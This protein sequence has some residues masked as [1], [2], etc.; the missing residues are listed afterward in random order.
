MELIWSRRPSYDLA[1]LPPLVPISRQ[2]I[3]SLTKS[4]FVL[5]PERGWGEG[6]RGAKSYDGEKAWSSVNHSILSE[7]PG[8]LRNPLTYRLCV[9]SGH[10]QIPC[11]YILEIRSHTFQLSEYAWTAGKHTHSETIS[12]FI[13]IYIYISIRWRSFEDHLG[14]KIKIWNST[15]TSSSKDD[16]K[17]RLRQFDGKK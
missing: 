14:P 6:G 7:E 13:Y 16:I 12:I 11:P 4:S 2:Q 8:G 1:P 15:K 3:V 10:L 5:R 9:P 17:I